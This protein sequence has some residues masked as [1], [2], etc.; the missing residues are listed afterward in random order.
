MGVKVAVASTDGKFIN[1]HFGR[2]REFLIF[3]LNEEE[4]SY[5][6]I[7][8][9]NNQPPCNEFEHNDNLLEESVNLLADCKAVLVS[10]IGPGAVHALGYKGIQALMIRDYIHDA[11]NDI[12]LS[13]INLLK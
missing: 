10:Q 2:A 12:L 3:D 1:Q 13:K 5:K 6:F 9:R 7:E 8:L 4:Q 11:L